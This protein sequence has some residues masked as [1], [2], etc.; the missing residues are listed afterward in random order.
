MP[1]PFVLTCG[2]STWR[3]TT[4]FTIIP[5]TASIA[6]LCGAAAASPV[7]RQ[8]SR[9]QYFPLKTPLALPCDLTTG[10]DGNIYGDTFTSNKIVQIDRPSGELTEYDI[11]YTLPV[12]GFDV[13]PSDVL[14]RVA[15]SCVV[16]PGKNGKIYAA[17]G[18]RNEFVI[19]DPITKDMTVLETGNPLGN[20]EPFNDAWP[21]ETGMFFTQ[22][23]ANV[24]NLI[25]YETN[26]ITN[27]TVPTPL[28]G[29]LGLIVGSDGGVWFCEFLA[30]CFNTPI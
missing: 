5:L 22:T 26:K 11:P 3:L 4:M 13:L 24:I 12:L 10:Q 20:L 15:L 1:S 16:Q 21:G 28:A 27:W 25:D 17:A 6:L 2:C 18:I 19:F 14:G 8:D 29:P 9:F 30:V 23:T 7:E